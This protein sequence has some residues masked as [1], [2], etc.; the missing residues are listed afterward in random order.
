M[1]ACTTPKLPLA[2]DEILVCI[3]SRA[4]PRFKF[5]PSTP[6]VA[7]GFTTTQPPLALR[8]ARF[9]H[10]FAE[11]PSGPAGLGRATVL[12]GDDF[13]GPRP[14]IVSLQSPIL[15]PRARRS[16][17]RLGWRYQAALEA[18]TGRPGPS[19]VTLRLLPAAQPAS[20]YPANSFKLQRPVLR[21]S[22]SKFTVG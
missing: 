16:R 12:L 2:L 11:P 10:H 22:V 9:A 17:L 19:T 3:A 4:D 21:V 8:L 18:R 13:S 5:A 14:A 6:L 15:A 7:H 20:S 1:Y